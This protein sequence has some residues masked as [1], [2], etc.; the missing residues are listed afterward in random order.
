MI[1]KFSNEI[2]KK[3]G[4]YKITNTIN[5]DFYIGSTTE[6]FCKRFSN[7]VSYW[8]QG[9]MTKKFKCPLLYKAFSKYGIDNFECEIIIYFTR[10]KDSITNKKII[11][12]I[13]EKYIKKYNPKYNVCKKPTLSGCPNLGKKLSEEWKNKIR[14]KSKL[15]KHSNNLIVYNNKIQQ[16]KNLSSKYRIYK[17][18]E[19]YT[20]SLIDISKFLNMSMGHVSQWAKNKY[21]NRKGWSIEKIK[22][23]RKKIK[24][25]LDNEIKIFNS[26]GECDRFLNMWRGYTSNCVVNKKNKILNYNY[27]L[28]N[29][30][31][32]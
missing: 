26:L 12:Y 22:S 1:V 7:H 5:N 13:E 9:L 2:C 31:I 19:E 3:W 4:V 6:N 15:Y 28:I 16:N 21:K 24:I 14:E 8:K 20:G 30:D 32:V 29:E 27:E 17:C 11:T 23:Q 25:Y 10:K 18:S